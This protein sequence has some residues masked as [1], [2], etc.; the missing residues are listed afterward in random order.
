MRP[1]P[2][3][4]EQASVHAHDYDLLFWTISGLTVLFTILVLA[5][6]VFLAI[7][8]R[9]GNKVDR[10]NA[11]DH[12]T[13]LELA[14]T[15]LPL[16]LAMGIFGWSSLN[17]VKYRTMPEEAID[18][19]V[20]GKQWMW[21]L[22]HMDGTREN[23][24]LHI[25]VGRPV[26]MTMIS[27]DVIHA[28]YLP[29]FRSQYHVVP[30]RYTTLQFTPTKTGRYRMLCAMHCGTQHSE[31]VGWV[32]VLSEKDFADW[33]AQKG[34]KFR[35]RAA[36]VA[37]AGRT[38]W[39]EKRCGNC[40][41]VENTVRGPSLNGILGKRR[42]FSDGSSMVADEDY[43]RASILDPYK[44]LTAGY[45]RT[46]PVYQGQITEED[47]LSLIAYIKSSGTGS[48]TGVDAPKKPFEREMNRSF[49]RQNEPENS[50]DTANRLK[51][52]GAAHAAEQPSK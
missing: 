17:F 26:K 10:R 38:L 46:M 32:H 41:G 33:Q 13:P 11:P 45:D 43:L 18:I 20:I 36:T 23:S 27:Q 15:I 1:I 19:F 29:E 30:G 40:H 22:Q 7:R 25:P 35:P 52:A 51:S 44:L 5:I 6:V 12:S 9:A 37:D 4:P 49:K 48:A 8:Y 42:T 3:V 50:T 24:E 16:I 14:W 21:H 39:N 2:L 28:M 31:M 47:V 34:N